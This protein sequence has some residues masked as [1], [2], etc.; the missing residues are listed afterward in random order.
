MN[1]T[2]NKIRKV[3]KRIKTSPGCKYLYSQFDDLVKDL[4]SFMVGELPEEVS[5]ELCSLIHD[6][7]HDSTYN[8][9]ASANWV[10]YSARCFYCADFLVHFLTEPSQKVAEELLNGVFL[11]LVEYRIAPIIQQDTL[12][13]YIE[14][15]ISPAKPIDL[16]D[17]LI[18]IAINEK[19]RCRLWC[20]SEVSL[21][22]SYN[23]SICW[24][25][26]RYVKTYSDY[27]RL[28]IWIPLLNTK[29]LA[30]IWYEYPDSAN[31]KHSG[32][33]TREYVERCLDNILEIHLSLIKLW[34]W[35]NSQ[36]MLDVLSLEDLIE[37]L[38]VYDD[39]DFEKI[40][41]HMVTLPFNE[42]V[43]GIL[44]HFTNDD[45]SWII[46][47]SNEL[48]CQYGNETKFSTN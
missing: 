39:D 35:Y 9:Y 10:R 19:L 13:K 44:K 1:N 11:K 26:Q 38:E 5:A 40:L 2:I 42:K 7:A 43:Y 30:K 27:S 41:R 15:N 48:L 3:K 33:Y 6:Y 25:I 34:Y 22:L 46:N 18:R 28:K 24:L 45:E 21:S 31:Y 14:R 36:E 32:E 8:T 12:T 37:A 23:Q 20:A 17:N 29:E 4:N 47:L 16:Y